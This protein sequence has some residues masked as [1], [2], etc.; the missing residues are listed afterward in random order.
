MP[1]WLNDL[2]DGQALLGIAALSLAALVWLIKAVTSQGRELRP[3]GG[4]SL[5]DAVSMILIAQDKAA[6]DMREIRLAITTETAR[7]NTRLD[8]HLRNH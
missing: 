8:D 3:N 4:S 6:D 5:H 2:N 1:D 7:L